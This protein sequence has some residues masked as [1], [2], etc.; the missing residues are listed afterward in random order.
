VYSVLGA[1]GDVYEYIWSRRKMEWT[2][3]VT[4]V[5]VYLQILKEVTN[6]TIW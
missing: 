5:Q 4:L 3:A 2:V 1:I 6:Y